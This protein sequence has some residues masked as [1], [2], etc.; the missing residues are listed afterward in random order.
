MRTI[1]R[2]R[3][4]K[5]ADFLDTVPSGQFDMELFRRDDIHTKDLYTCDTAGCAMGWATSIIRSDVVDRFRNRSGGINFHSIADMYYGCGY[6]TYASNTFE[7]LFGSCWR[8]IDNTPEGA[9]A[10]IRY[11]LDKG[12]PI[13]ANYE[14]AVELYKPYI[15]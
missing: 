5:L 3:L 4:A 13:V 15:K 7:F 14:E 6:F 12:L 9:A 11:F 10:R 2:K 8:C 1:Y